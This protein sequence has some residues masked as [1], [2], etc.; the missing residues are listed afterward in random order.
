MSS[1]F[2]YSGAFVADVHALL[3]NGGIYGY[4]ADTKAP[5]GKLRLLY[6]ANPMSFLIEQVRGVRGEGGG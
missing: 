3:N 5:Q 1:V 6:E 4:P 2:K